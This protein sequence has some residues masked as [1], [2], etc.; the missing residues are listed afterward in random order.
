MLTGEFKKN[1]GV[2]DGNHSQMALTKYLTKL[3]YQDFK[4]QISKTL[5]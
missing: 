5:T 2:N 1:P 4:N 3:V